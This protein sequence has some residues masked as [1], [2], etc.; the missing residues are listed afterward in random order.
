MKQNIAQIVQEIW[1]RYARRWRAS[2][3]NTMKL[4]RALPISLLVITLQL[5]PLRTISCTA[6]AQN[7]T[8]TGSTYKL[9]NGQ[10]FD[11]KGFQRR[12]YYSVNGFLTQK[13]PQSVDE[14]IDLQN[15][16]VVPPFADAH[17]HN[18]YGAYNIA[19][20]VG[21][22]LKEGIFYAKVLTDSRKGALQ[23]A[24]KVNIPT[25]VD[26]SYAHGAL[27]H[28][29]GHGFEIF[30]ALALRIPPE[31]TIIAANRDKIAA[32]HLMENDAYYIIDT[33]E[34]LENKWQ[35]ILAG[36]PDFIKVMLVGSERFAEKE[37]N[38]AKIALGDIGVNPEIL[39]AI[40]EKAHQAGLR[41]SVHVETVV[42]Y[43]L[44]LKAGVDE[45]AHMPGYY[46]ADDEKDELKTLTDEDARETARR[47]IWVVLAPIALEYNPAQRARIDRLLKL[48]I[49]LLKKYNVKI[50]FGS[51]RYGRTPLDDVLH[52]QTLGVFTN[53]E[54]LRIW[55]EVTPLTIFPNRKI[56]RLK[57][58]YEASFIVLNG[59][60]VKEFKQV[61][62][63]RLRFKQGRSIRAAAAVVR[64]TEGQSGQ[65][66]SSVTL[67]DI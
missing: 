47:G 20:Q 23:V 52:L 33:R 5:F 56:G 38:L 35:K 21:M 32:S 43:R 65:G 1:L 30:E 48:N 63:I 18:F 40:V 24:D 17:C 39:P 3:N 26:V 64:S 11:G 14:I 15:G 45:M 42:D 19:E 67:T 59:N 7:A 25:S 4:R 66:S 37:Q 57:E 55:C 22:Y 9:I 12:T 6:V 58:G 36:K 54:M 60:P 8:Q 31:A 44:A 10:W 61:R 41:V 51:D 62:N 34:D 28:T 50:A 2:L 46:V 29:F 49:E 53:L 13:R 16:Y 27:T